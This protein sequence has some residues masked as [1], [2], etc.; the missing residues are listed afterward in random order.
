MM[1]SYQL[2][3]GAIPNFLALYQSHHG[4]ALSSGSSIT[5]STDL[6]PDMDSQNAGL[7]PTCN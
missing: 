7:R 4:T 3:Y 1:V 2:H 6:K 5:A